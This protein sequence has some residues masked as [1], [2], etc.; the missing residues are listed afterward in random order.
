M[1]YKLST[2]NADIIAAAKA[3]GITLE[4]ELKKYVR[5]N[6]YQIDGKAGNDKDWT[7]R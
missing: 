5:V 6:F 4:E 7:L 2:I 3:A 1:M